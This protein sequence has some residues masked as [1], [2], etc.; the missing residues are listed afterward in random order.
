MEILDN[1]FYNN[2][3]KTWLIA[4]GILILSMLLLILIKKI[5]LSRLHKLSHKT[6]TD[7][8]DLITEHFA[9]IKTLFLAIISIYFASLVLTLTPRIDNILGKLVIVALLIQGAIWA[10]GIILYWIERQKKQKLE[11]DAASATT[12]SALSYVVRIFIWAIILL[13]IL[14]NLGIDITTLVAGLGIGGIAVALALQNVLSDLFASLSIILDKP[15]VIGDFII[16]GDYLGS[17]EHIGLKTTRVRSLSG[18]QLVFSNNDLLQSR[19]RNYK[20]M[21]QRR[22]VFTIGVIYQT[23]HDKLAKI[24]GMIKEIIE[25]I[26]QVR[27]DRSHFKAYGDFS[28]NIEPVYWVESPDY[29]VYMDIQQKINLMIYKQFEQEG[30]EFA[31]P[32][33]TLYFNQENNHPIGIQEEQLKEKPNDGK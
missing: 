9:N 18:E 16:V 33:Q 31:Y 12:F 2:T 32:T 11:V 13:L 21:L 25:S 26:D 29:N 19:I 23:P 28:L 4:L 6:K 8:D 14:D 22:I 17:V 7:I 30:I 27:F 10:T 20:R 5:V 3:V 15:F 24:P 1:T